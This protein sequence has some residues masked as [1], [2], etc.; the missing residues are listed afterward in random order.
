LDLTRLG[1]ILRTYL[2]LLDVVEAASRVGDVDGTGVVDVAAGVGDYFTDS[3][4][5][6]RQL[7]GVC[8]DWAECILWVTECPTAK[9][10]WA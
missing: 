10:A 7:E 6:N 2:E 9:S 1:W 4:C 3:H 8:E 5:C